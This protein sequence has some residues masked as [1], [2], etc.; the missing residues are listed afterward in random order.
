MPFREHSGPVHPQYFLNRFVHLAILYSVH[1]NTYC[2]G[3]IITGPG[4]LLAIRVLLMAVCALLAA[5]EQG[6][7]LFWA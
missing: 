5:E 3:Q 2:A 6:S 7:F 4:S 1:I